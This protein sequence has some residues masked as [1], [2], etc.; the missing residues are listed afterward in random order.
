MCLFIS[1]LIACLYLNVGEFNSVHS[2][3]SWLLRVCIIDFDWSQ[4]VT[5]IIRVGVVNIYVQSK[6]SLSKLVFEETFARCETHVIMA[7]ARGICSE[8]MRE[9]M[10][11]I[12]LD[13]VWMMRVFIR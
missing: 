2:V 7:C 10:D 11:G 9:K 6:D 4:R 8:V 13:L 5:I 1:G 12:H 3:Y